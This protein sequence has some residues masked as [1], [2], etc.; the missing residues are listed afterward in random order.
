MI[1]AVTKNT[2]V[3]G[4]C[5]FG[6]GVAFALDRA[7]GLGSIAA[8]AVSLLGLVKLAAGLRACTTQLCNP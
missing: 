5:G 3:S 6:F 2:I 4:F 1:V 8:R 7:G